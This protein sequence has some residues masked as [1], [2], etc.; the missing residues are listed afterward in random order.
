MTLRVVLNCP[1]AGSCAG[2]YPTLP[3]CIGPDSW[4]PWVPA[5]EA[6]MRW[7][8]EIVQ[9]RFSSRFDLDRLDPR[10]L[11]AQDFGWNRAHRASSCDSALA[12]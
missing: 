6:M 9:F 3:R 1:I 11:N 4:Y 12:V 5:T 2:K 8:V 7:S 10:R